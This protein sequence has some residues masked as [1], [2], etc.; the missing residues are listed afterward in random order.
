MD[1]AQLLQFAAFAVD[2]TLVQV[3]EGLVLFTLTVIHQA[4]NQWTCR[5][6]RRVFDSSLLKFDRSIHHSFSS[7]AFSSSSGLHVELLQ[8]IESNQFPY[9][10]RRGKLVS[11]KPN[12][13]QRQAREE[14]LDE[15]PEIGAHLE[16]EGQV[17]ELDEDAGTARLAAQRHAARVPLEFLQ[18]PF[19][20]AAVPVDPRRRLHHGERHLRTKKEKTVL[21]NDFPWN[22]NE[23]RN[24]SAAVLVLDGQRGAERRALARRRLQLL[25]AA[26]AAHLGRRVHR[27]P[28]LRHMLQRARRQ[29]TRGSN[30]K[31]NLTLASE[32]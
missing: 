8:R 7:E 27:R 6:R 10:T 5:C 12:R 25:D 1:A 26:V 18:L 13:S 21:K 24:L 22:I 23:T 17:G 11:L 32:I 16:V 28:H 19:G 14:R 9:G 3:L 2:A 30:G 4:I 29:W 15:S 20:G 31:A